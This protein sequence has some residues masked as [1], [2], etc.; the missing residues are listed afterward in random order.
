MLGNREMDEAQERSH[1]LKGAGEVPDILNGPSNL[2]EL[3]D[4]D[5]RGAH[6]QHRL[7]A[8][9]QI[10]ECPPAVLSSSSSRACGL[11]KP[12]RSDTRMSSNYNGLAAA[13]K[14]MIALIGPNASALVGIV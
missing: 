9:P 13:G 12:S 11:L 1:S 14:W 6:V 4:F 7:M 10:A 5:A 2:D 3:F 8:A